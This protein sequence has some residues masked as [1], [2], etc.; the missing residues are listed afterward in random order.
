MPTYIHKNLIVHFTKMIDVIEICP[1][2]YNEKV[3]KKIIIIKKMIK[4]FNKNYF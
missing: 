1:S 4:F 3:T 2:D